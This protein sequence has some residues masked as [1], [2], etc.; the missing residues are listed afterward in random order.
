MKASCCVFLSK[1]INMK[2]MQN[3][4]YVCFFFHLEIFKKLMQNRQD[5]IEEYLHCFRVGHKILD[6]KDKRERNHAW[7]GKL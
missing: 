7:K 2:L 3:R 1:K 4:H 6:Q 5:F